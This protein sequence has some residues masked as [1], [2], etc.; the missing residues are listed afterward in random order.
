M[1]AGSDVRPSKDK[2]GEG[3]R[4]KHITTKTIHKILTTWNEKGERWF[5]TV[6][7]NLYV[8]GETLSWMGPETEF[9][10]QFTFSHH[11]SAV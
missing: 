10:K 2:L 6:Q 3:N 7:C 8:L 1:D 4:H 9:E 5:V 11:E